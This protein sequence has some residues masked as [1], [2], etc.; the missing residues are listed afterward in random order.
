MLLFI[1]AALRD[2]VPRGVS[3][4]G[5]KSSAP[6]YHDLMPRVAAVSEDLR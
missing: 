3:D 4:G 2:R 5:D 6:V 1:W